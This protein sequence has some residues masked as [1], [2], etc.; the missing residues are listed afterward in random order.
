MSNSQIESKEKNMTGLSRLSLILSAAAVIMLLAVLV[1]LCMTDNFELERSRSNADFTVVRDCKSREVKDADAP[2]GVHKEYTFTLQDTLETDTCL[3]FYTVHQYVEIYIDGQCVY[4]LRPSG[5]SFIKTIGSNWT[6]IPLYREDA[7]KE[8]RVNIIPVYRSFR[9]REVEFLV[10]SRLSIC[11]DRLHK[12]YPQLLLSGMAIFVGIVFLCIAGYKLL[13]KCSD[14][15]LASLGL[16]SVMVG[17]WRFTDMRFTPF[18]AP[19]KPVLMFYIS[20]FMLM[21]G[22]VPLI[23][24]T[25]VRIHK[26]S[27]SILDWYCIA[28]ALLCIVQLLLQVFGGIDLRENIII[29]HFMI[30]VGTVLLVGSMIFERIKYPGNEED[31]VNPKAV[32]LLAAGVLADIISFYIRKTSSGLLF[33]LLALLIYILFKGVHMLFSHVEKEKQLAE[34]ERMLAEN[35][36]RLAESRIET[37][38][39]QIRPHFIYNTLGS[40]EQLCELQ[41]ETAAKLVHNF[42][43][44]LRGNF[45][46][47]DN[48]A[49]IH[50]SQEIEHT[51]YYASIEQVRF[52]DIEIIFDLKASDFLI[53]ALSVQPLVENSIKHGLMKLDKGGTVTISSFENDTHYYVSVKD[54][55]VGFDTSILLDER[56]HIGLRNIRSRLES[57]CSGTLTVE[58]A[59]GSGTTVFIMIPR[60]VGK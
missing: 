56:K 1:Y 6:M 18:L 29:T 55:G 40:I 34:K 58:S 20:V 42:S 8:I 52:P 47:L 32:I 51:K 23:K 50:L 38:I 27:S 36:R 17:L 7:G 21:V 13:H 54:N 43:R 39:S 33:S 26:S 4:Q 22:I 53:P 11:M 5:K 14:E 57:M 10:G 12:D 45:S 44:Y 31:A 49:P 3:A 16:F 41:P 24:S 25:E 37:M 2:V 46:E 60:E 19:G 48:P 35:E 59:P 30:A 15:G 9:S 28:V